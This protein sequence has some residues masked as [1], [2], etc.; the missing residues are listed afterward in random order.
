MAC[1]I[2]RWVGDVS[3]NYIAVPLVIDTA[4]PISALRRPNNWEW[5][6]AIYQEL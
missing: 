3:A 2:S 1:L 5:I 4:S 6:S